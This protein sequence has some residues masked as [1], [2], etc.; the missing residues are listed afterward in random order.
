[1]TSF[2]FI[3]LTLVECITVEKLARKDAKMKEKCEMKNEVNVNLK[4][5]ANLIQTQLLPFRLFQKF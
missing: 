3:F 2:L 4:E 5:N 1:M